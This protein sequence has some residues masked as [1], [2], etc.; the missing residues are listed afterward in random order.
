VLLLLTDHPMNLAEET[1]DIGIRFGEPP[2][3]R[4][5][6]RKIAPTSGRFLLRQ[7]TSRCVADP[8]CRM[9]CR[10]TIA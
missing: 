3:S 8:W 10:T 7:V 6:A 4:M 9:T 2:D 5:V 1:I